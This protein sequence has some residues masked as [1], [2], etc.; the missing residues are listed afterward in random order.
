MFIARRLKAWLFVCLFASV[1]ALAAP[2]ADDFVRWP[3]ITSTSI[4]D[5]GRHLAYFT[6]SGREYFNLNITDLESGKT[7]RFELQGF[8][9]TGMWWIDNDQ[10]LLYTK[11]P[12]NQD[13]QIAVFSVKRGKITGYLMHEITSIRILDSLR[14]DPALFLAHFPESA[15]WD[16]GRKGLAIVSSN[17]S[18]SGISGVKDNRYMVKE[19]LTIPPGEYHGAATDSEGELRLLVLYENKKMTY[20][21]RPGPEEPWQTLPFDTEK[22]NI[23]DFDQDPDYLYV[24]HYAEASHTSSLYRYRI[25]TGEFGDPIY[26]DPYYSMYDSSLLSVRTGKGKVRHLAL[27]YNRDIRVQLPIDPE[28]AAVQKEINALLPGRLNSIYDC[29][30]NLQRF[31]V[32]STSGRDT[33]RYVIYTRKDKSMMALPEGRPWLNPAEAS[34]MR[35]IKFKARDGLQLEGYL[36][37]PAPRADGKKPPLIV[38][39]HGGP[40]VRDTWGFNTEVQFFTSRGY[41]VFQPNYRGSTGYNTAISKTDDFEFR[42]MHDDVTDGVRQLIEQGVVDGDRVAIFGGSFG[43]YLAV[44]GAA[45]EPDL[46]R[47]AITFAG[48]FDWQQLIRQR[49]TDSKYDKFNYDVLMEKLGDPKT[50]EERFNAMS[51]INHVA[52][53][54]CPVYVIHGKLDGTVNYKQSTRLLSELNAH[55]IPHEKLFF[56]TEFHGFAERKNYREFLEAVEVFLTKHL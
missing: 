50:Q 52:D 14:R 38:N 48:V 12:E 39:P 26:S 30:K 4:A 28:F 55:E 54:K 9:A 41:A 25:S 21:Y 32:F 49:W 23:I 11:H 40:W 1:T 34:L 45:F 47:C 37:L 3:E 33:P 29:D 36:S 44:A 46:Y 24:G 53:I 5:D 43:G 35:P 17:R 31:V 18:P 22:T 7:E 56:A 13:F 6:P 16:T 10:I 51:P 42:K 19:W 2:P 20:R 15:E 8:D 27:N